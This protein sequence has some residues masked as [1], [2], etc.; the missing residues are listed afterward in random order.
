MAAGMDLRLLRAAVFAAVC[1][2]LSAAGHTV[3]AGSSLP[4]WA[5][6]AGFAASFA[7]AVPLA[8]R[9][10]SLPGITAVLAAGQLVLHTLF[11]CGGRTHQ[12]A[13][14]AGGGSGE[15]SPVVEFATRLICGDP[16]A[17]LGLS[18][19]RARRIVSD[20]G[21]SPADVAQRAGQ[22][23]GAGA[24]TTGADAHA[25]HGA[26]AGQQSAGLVDS[27]L[28]CLRGAAR[29]ALTTL[30]VPML[31]GHLVAAVLL[32]LLLRRGEA[33]L[34]RLVR[35]SAQAAVA[36]D[37]L[38]TLRA[39]RAAIGYARLMCCELLLETPVP[40]GAESARDDA[41]PRSVVL[42][43]SVQRRGPPPSAPS[44]LALAA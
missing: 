13:H 24:A 3:A 23:G 28:D 31:L 19:A 11:A 14:G 9:E 16:S 38:L 41:V 4:L 18:E 27:P 33:A 8:G 32:G 44:S 35:L 39:L 12:A 7:L 20:A 17:S 22:P 40:P 37:E 42:Q 10:R 15:R 21:I 25:A 6:A 26:H 43:H 1:V 30:D 2:A 36:A 34:W 29:S 5:L